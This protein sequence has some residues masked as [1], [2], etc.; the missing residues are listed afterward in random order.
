MRLDHAAV[1]AEFDAQVRRGTEPD[2][3][4]SLA[5]RVG[6]V[7]RW[8]AAGGPGWSGISWSDLDA[9]TAD[10]VIADQLRF[11]RGR[12]ERFEWKLYSYDQPADLG[13]R[14]LAA[15]FVREDAESLMIAEVAELVGLANG[16]ELPDG[17]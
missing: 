1:L 17:V 11:F 14:L 10:E 6:P 13:Q 15:G 9:G 16:P 7:V 12:G 5:E 4:G 2:G 3:S 8:T